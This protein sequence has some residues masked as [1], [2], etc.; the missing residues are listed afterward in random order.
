MFIYP[1][2][3]LLCGVVLSRALAARTA[4]ARPMAMG[5]GVVLL[6]GVMTGLATRGR[7]ARAEEMTVLRE[8]VR[9]TQATPAQTIYTTDHRWSRALE[10]FDA[11]LV[12]AT[13]D[14]ATFILVR[15]PLD[16]PVV[17]R[18]PAV[19]HGDSVPR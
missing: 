6:V 9:A 5:F 19:A 12:S 14:A 2:L 18:G 3:M 8:I 15:G 11:S 10:V 13:A 7:I 4:L 1:P 17:Q 16:L